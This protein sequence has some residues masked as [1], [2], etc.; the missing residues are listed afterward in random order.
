MGSQVSRDDRVSPR[1]Y[2]QS[3]KPVTYGVP[4]SLSIARYLNDG[5]ES[6]LVT[7]LSRSDLDVLHSIAP[8]VIATIEYA[9]TILGGELH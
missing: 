6:S 1:L 7:H 2:L 5:Q 8:S 4:D 3:A 9:Q